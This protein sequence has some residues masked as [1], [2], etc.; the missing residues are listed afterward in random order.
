MSRQRGLLVFV[1]ALALLGLVLAGPVRA[2]APVR[3]ITGYLPDSSSFLIEVPRPWNGTL[4]LYSHGYRVPG[5]PNPA[6]DV[7]DPLTREWLLDH[8]YALAGSSYPKTGWA[9]AEAL[10]AQVATLDKFDRLVG[11]PRRTIAWGHSLGGIIT[12]G[13]IQR[14]PA[15]F[16]AALPMCGVLGGG[17][18][19]WNQA[20]DSAFAFKHLVAPGSALRVV[21]IRNTTENLVLA[22]Q[23]LAAAQATAEG[24]A[25]IALA[26]ALAN[27]PGW[28]DPASPEPGPRQ[29]AVRQANQFRWLQQ[30]NFP[31]AFF[32]RA[33]LEARAGGNPSWN[34]G[35]D[36]SRQ[37]RLSGQTGLVEALYRQAG[38]S[39][40]A[41]LARLGRAPRISADP[42]AVGYLVRN[43]IYT[44][45]L[46]VPVLALHTTDDGLVP[47]QHEQA[48][49][50][51]VR[52]AG[53]GHLLRQTYVHR[54]GHCTFTPAET[55]TAF[56]T[57]VARLD[58]GG[59]DPYLTNP[60]RLNRAARALGPVY[61]EPVPPAYVSFTPTPFL[62]PYDVRDLTGR[63]AAAA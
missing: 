48:Y 55:I 43:L 61:N 9:L 25:R 31:F 47:V 20:L 41:D 16:D 24:R 50:S 62:R 1:A 37:L 30:V 22:Q 54:A 2:Q 19:T 35:V 11:K 36:Y 58:G 6:Q 42:R 44:G 17:V 63:A 39:L 60:N 59:W 46:R 4:V 38:L 7:G 5:G 53:G 56:R 3:V 27:V 26:A 32:L 34:T 52:A 12:A 33:E 29:F 14:Y 15:R 49:R 18:G 21:N 40:R 8:G 57:L 28:F 45:Q 13:L 23:L 10:P 51:V